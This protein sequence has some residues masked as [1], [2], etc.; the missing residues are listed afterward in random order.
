MKE[1]V[2][3]IV[4]QQAN[5]QSFKII[6][7]FNEKL[8]H[9]DIWQTIISKHKELAQYEYDYFPRGRVWVKDKKATIFLNPII[10]TPLILQK[11]N[12]IFELKENY[13]VSID[14]QK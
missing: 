5:R 1:G 10:N 11:I 6:F 4:F 2:F 13:V 12:K 14:T 9:F 7:E 8:G 3:W